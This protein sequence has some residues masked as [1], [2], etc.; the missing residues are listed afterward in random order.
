MLRI[1]LLQNGYALS[2]P[3]MQEALYET[4][5][6]RAFAKLSPRGPIPDETTIL[7]FRRLPETNELEWRACTILVTSV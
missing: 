7:N 5:P 2:D 3:A 6:L 4:T 1:H